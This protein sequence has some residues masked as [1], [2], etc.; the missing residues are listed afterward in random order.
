MIWLKAEVK[1]SSGSLLTNPL[2]SRAQIGVREHFKGFPNPGGGLVWRG[3][4]I[5]SG[6]R[7][8]CNTSHANSDSTESPSRK[9][10]S[11]PPDSSTRSVRHGLLGHVVV[12]QPTQDFGV[13][14]SSLAI[15]LRVGRIGGM[16][17]IIAEPFAADK[18]ITI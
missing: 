17:D 14:L 1:E 7:G 13:S 11:R 18:V 3:Q 15:R 8:P 4:P 5:A 10:L 6:G 9:P 12:G 16:D 2:V